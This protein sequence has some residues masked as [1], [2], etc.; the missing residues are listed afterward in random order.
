ME[1]YGLD[2]LKDQFSN[3]AIDYCTRFVA[4][5]PNANPS[6][7]LDH[8]AGRRSRVDAINGMVPILGRELG[9]ETPYNNAMVAAIRAREEK[10]RLGF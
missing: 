4:T 5:M 2:V 10:F 7:R 8:L 6:M 1:A 9:I 3:D